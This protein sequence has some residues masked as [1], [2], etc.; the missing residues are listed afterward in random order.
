MFIP[1]NPSE[2]FDL[3]FN[4]NKEIFKVSF[5]PNQGTFIFNPTLKIKKDRTSSE[6][7]FSQNA[8]K[9]TEKIELFSKSL[10]GKKEKSKIEILYIDSLEFS[11]R[12]K[13]MYCLFTYS[14]KFENS[15]KNLKIYAKCFWITFGIQQQLTKLM[16]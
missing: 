9:I 3:S 7:T 10:E 15:T 5:I 12:I 16:N 14:S 1:Q 2:I 6:K 13:I 8:V 11:V 4:N